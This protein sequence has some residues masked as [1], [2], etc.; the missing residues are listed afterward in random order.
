MSELPLFKKATQPNVKAQFGGLPCD[1]VQGLCPELAAMLKGF[2]MLG[3]RRRVAA[4][5]ATASQ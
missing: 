4:Q 2:F 1:G 5:Q 3:P